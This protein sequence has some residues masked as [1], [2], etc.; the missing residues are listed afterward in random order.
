M[1]KWQSCNFG[2]AL[3]KEHKKM[4]NSIL[5]LQGTVFLYVMPLQDRNLLPQ[6]DYQD[7]QWI[8]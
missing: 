1:D 4:G 8:Y 3:C 6:G 5:D 7:P 2:H